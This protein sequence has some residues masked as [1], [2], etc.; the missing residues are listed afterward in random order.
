M[1]YFEYLNYFCSKFDFPSNAV[2][3]LYNSLTK[4]TTCKSACLKLDGLIFD[5]EKSY[6]IDYEKN[7][8]VIKDIAALSS[9]NGET[10]L[11]IAYILMSKK[12]K[13][14][15]SL[16]GY[17]DAMWVDAMSDLKDRLNEC[18]AV[19]KIWGS[20]TDW[21][22]RFFDFNL[23]A[24][25]RLQFN[26]SYL[27]ADYNKDGENLKK[28]DKVIG[29]HIPGG[30]PLDSR[31][32]IDSFNQ[33]EKFFKNDFDKKIP[34]TCKTYLFHSSMVNLYKPTSN[35]KWFYDLFDVYY[36]EDTDH[37]LDA[38]RI[39]NCQVKDYATLPEKTSL[40]KGLKTHLLNGGKMGVGVGILFR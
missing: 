22:A 32:V 40:Q 20:D 24:L 25:G 8:G 17:S 4:I 2:E 30:R 1:N 33:A 31:A 37:I 7:N 27:Y 3:H 13:E 12:L 34:F 28:G 29:V 11:L 36:Q 18:F 16:K 35:L 15:Y 5:Y 21:F 19:K 26:Y 10:V 38:W 23:F 39:F 9:V 6:E 14:Y